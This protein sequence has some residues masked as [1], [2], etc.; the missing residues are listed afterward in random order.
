MANVKKEDRV[1]NE[2]VRRLNH[3]GL[4][5]KAIA[6]HLGCNAATVTLRLKEMNLTPVDTRRSFME[7]IYKSL[8]PEEQ[9]WLSHNLLVNDIPIH[10]FVV[11]LI[12][13]AYA[14]DPG[15]TSAAPVPMPEMIS[16]APVSEVVSTVTP[17][18]LEEE[19]EETELEAPVP[20]KLFR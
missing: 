5:L 14:T 12:K 2:D 10:E 9:D 8:S 16:S 18:K 19:E 3:L 1:Q 17:E 6:E 4:G 13:Q 7:K 11:G 20:H 15:Q